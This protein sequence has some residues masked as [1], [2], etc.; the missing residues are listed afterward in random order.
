MSDLVTG[1]APLVLA[2]TSRYRAGLLDSLGLLYEQV[3]PEVDE[4]AP[5]FDGL[6]P[7]ELAATLA[8]VKADAVRARRPD[9]VVLGSDQ[10]CAL[11][12]RRFDKPGT[13]ERAVETLLA[14]AGRTHTLWTALVVAGPSATSLHVDETRLTMAYHDR[15]AL[16]RYVAR[17]R[18]L[19][20]AGSYKLEALG[21]ALFE[22]VETRDPSAIVGLPKSALCAALR[23]LGWPLP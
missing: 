15:A 22:R 16:E 4:R 1:P 5:R 13:P 12:E 10:V 19:D 2:S 18:P 11:G 8:R 21:A 7:G 20:C 6:G 3:A 14:L 17:D 23:E 9:A